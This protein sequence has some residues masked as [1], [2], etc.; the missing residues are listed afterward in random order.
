MYIKSPPTLHFCCVFQLDAA[1][2]EGSPGLIKLSSDKSS[3]TSAPAL[4]SLPVA[5]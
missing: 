2:E 3:G 4:Q 1:G 5:Y